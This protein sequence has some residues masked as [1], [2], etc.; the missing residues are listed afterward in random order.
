M[1]ALVLSFVCTLLFTHRLLIV[2]FIYATLLC[3][4][5]KELN[6]ICHSPQ[7]EKQKKIIILCVKHVS[8][9]DC[10]FTTAI[11]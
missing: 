11:D 7:E 1:S 5:F 4:I 6:T 3:V 8:G 2:R 10:Q 9:I